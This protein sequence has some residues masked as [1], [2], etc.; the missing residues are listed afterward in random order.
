M[1]TLLVMLHSSFPLILLLG[2]LSAAQIILDGNWTNTAWL[3]GSCGPLTQEPG[4]SVVWNFTGTYVEIRGPS[5]VDL[6]TITVSLDGAPSSLSPN[7]TG[8]NAVLYQN[9]SLP[10]GS[11]TLNFTFVGPASNVSSLSIASFACGVDSNIV[12]A[13]DTPFPSGTPSTSNTPSA[14]GTPSAT[15]SSATGAKVGGALGGVVGTALLAAVAT[16]QYF[17]APAASSRNY[18]F[19]FLPPVVPI[20]FKGKKLKDVEIT[21]VLELNHLILETKQPEADFKFPPKDSP[22]GDRVAWKVMKLVNAGQKQELSTSLPVNLGF[23]DIEEDPEQRDRLKKT[24]SFSFA[25]LRTL[26][27]RTDKP[28]WEYGKL[29]RPRLEALVLAHNTTKIPVAFALGTFHRINGSDDFSPFLELPDVQ[30]GEFCIAPQCRDLRVNA[31]ITQN[32]HERQR[33]REE[34][35]TLDDAITTANAP[36][37]QNDDDTTPPE[38]IPEARLDDDQTSKIMSPALLGETGTPISGLKQR[39]CWRLVHEHGAWKLKVV[40]PEKVQHPARAADTPI[41]LRPLLARV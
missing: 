11:H 15:R 12:L 34:Y 39:T 35:R 37:S 13:S 36:E 16:Y 3:G 21:I 17:K 4:S 10:L 18:E 22:P 27:E 26:V 23:G 7:G 24:V 19:V 25:P 8:C 29:R 2:S 14:S 30:P 6:G 38:P 28:S 5:P 40:E 32:I 31:Y 41:E 33:L 1:T 9:T 20:W